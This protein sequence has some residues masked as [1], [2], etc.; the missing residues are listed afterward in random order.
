[1]KNSIQI[2]LKEYGNV[3]DKSIDWYFIS[4][5]E[6]NKWNRKIARIKFYQLQEQ[7]AKLAR[8][9]DELCQ[10]LMK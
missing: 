3:Q 5:N 10:N 1:M 4:C 9:L 2:C 6:E 8:R 7:R